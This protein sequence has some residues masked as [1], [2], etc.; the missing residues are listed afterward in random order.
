MST[1]A[2]PVLFFSPCQYARDRHRSL[3]LW[4][5]LWTILLF[6]FG[7]AIVVFLVVSI[8]FFIQKSFLPGALTMLGTI[9]QGAG[10]SWVAARR[11]DAVKEEVEAYAGV[12]KHCRD[13]QVGPEL[14]GATIP[15]ADQSVRDLYLIGKIR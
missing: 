5:N 10:I 13:L 9:V 4:R 14:A 12:E 15:G 6:G 11:A 1:P 8:T 7:A 2:S 3:A